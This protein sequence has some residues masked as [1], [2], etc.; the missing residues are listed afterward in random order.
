[1]KTTSKKYLVLPAWA[2]SAMLL[3][4]QVH[5]QQ[6]DDPSQPERITAQPMDQ[7]PSNTN[8]GEA[9]SLEEVDLMIQ[10]EADQSLR[11]MSHFLNSLKRFRF[12]TE[13]RF[14]VIDENG[15]KIQMTRRTDLKMQR[16]DRIFGESVGDGDRNN[17]FWFDGKNVTI[18]HR[19]QNVYSQ[20]SAQG[21]VDDMLDLMNREYGVAVPTADFLFS[22]VYK[23]LSG[24]VRQGRL[25]GLSLVGDTL[26]RHL[27]FQGEYVDWQIWIDAGSTPLPKKFVV[28]Y[29]TMEGSP[30]FSAE[31]LFWDIEPMFEEGVFAFTAPNGA[32]KID[33]LPVTPAMTAREG[34]E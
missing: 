1:M 7:E 26:C 29:K 6:S 34:D 23:T 24:D 30:Q 16:P 27:A 20:V 14:D 12:I 25:V 2:L 31:F 15:Q 8:A 13:N 18:L 21:N 5:A 10:P 28:D 33:M 11:S 4:L 9:E 22:D 32:A 19:L 17:A 3:S